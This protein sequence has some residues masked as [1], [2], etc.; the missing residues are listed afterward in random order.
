MYCNNNPLIYIDP[1]GLNDVSVGA[2]ESG[3]VAVNHKRQAV[4]VQGDEVHSSTDVNGRPSNISSDARAEEEKARD[5]IYDLESDTFK[6]EF[7]DM[8]AEDQLA[9]MQ[10]AHL[11]GLKEDGRN[12]GYI[13]SKLRGLRAG[14]K[15]GGLFGKAKHYMNKT[16]RKFLN[17]K[18]DGTN[19]YKESEMDKLGFKPKEVLGSIY[20]QENLV[21]D[22]LNTKYVHEDGREV[23]FFSDGT[24]NETEGDRGTFNYVN[25]TLGNSLGKGGG[26]YDY[27]IKP[28]YDIDLKGNKPNV[29]TLALHTLSK[30][31]KP[32]N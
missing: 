9:F 27:D 1:T 2:I 4:S 21:N 32:G 13:A 25:G 3:A 12:K 28:Y 30:V 31:E 11:L 5:I 26:H 29:F 16:M 10:E 20:H 8:S 23:V 14:M 19:N 15:L 7:A 17:L 18:K 22:K 6:D 24:I